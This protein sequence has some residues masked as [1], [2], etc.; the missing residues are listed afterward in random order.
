M[1]VSQ[2]EKLKHP[3]T[4]I[5]LQEKIEWGSVHYKFATTCGDVSDEWDYCQQSGKGTGHRIRE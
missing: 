3:A 4:E 5:G 2:L 1:N